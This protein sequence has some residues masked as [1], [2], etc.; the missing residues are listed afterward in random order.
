MRQQ[1][2][3]SR[4]GTLGSAALHHHTSS[5]RTEPE[6][7]KQHNRDKRGTGDNC[8]DRLPNR[9]SKGRFGTKIPIT[10]ADSYETLRCAFQ[11]ING[12]HHKDAASKVRNGEGFKIHRS[13]GATVLGLEETNTEWNHNDGHGMK[14]IRKQV[15]GA[16]AHASCSFSTSRLKH[17][18]L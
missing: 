17:T 10:Y 11:N 16:Y 2:R 9:Q 3:T 6:Q 8:T 1:T 5:A 4:W 7:H 12:F 15:I 13:V 14:S 18:A